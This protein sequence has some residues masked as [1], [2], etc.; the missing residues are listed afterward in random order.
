MEFLGVIQNTDIYY[1]TPELDLLRQAVFVRIRNKRELQFKFNRERDKA[2]VESTEYVFPLDMDHRLMQKMS[3]LFS[4]LLPHWN[5][6]LSIETAI[7]RNHLIELARIEN[8]R[9][10]YSD[11]EMYLNLDHVKDLG[12]F[13]EIEACCEEGTDTTKTL[14]VLQGFAQELTLYPLSIGYVE[15]WLRIYNLQAYLLGSYLL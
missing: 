12:V 11:G 1:D 7:V 4:S 15:M 13:L 5:A 9:E 10:V 8:T 2:H 3:D 14:A 6:E